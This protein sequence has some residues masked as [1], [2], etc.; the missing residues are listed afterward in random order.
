MMRLILGALVFVLLSGNVVAEEPFIYDDHGKRDP[1]WKLVTSSGAV[2]NY[3]T[4]V[5]VSDMALEGIIYDPNGNS[6]AVI[7]GT[8]VKVNNRIGLYVVSKIEEKKVTLLKG[9]EKFILELKKEE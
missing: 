5:L 9:E 3:D 4:D 6:L 2:M 8:V 1:F 7:N